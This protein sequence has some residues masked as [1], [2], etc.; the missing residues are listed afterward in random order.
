MSQTEEKHRFVELAKSDR[1]TIT[2]LCEE[3]GISR[4]T[5]H[6]WLY[7]FAS[8]GAA[9][10]EEHSRAPKRQ[11]ARTANDIEKIIVAERRLHETWGAKKIHARLSNKHGIERPP[12]VSTVGEILKRNGLIK[13]RRRRSGKFRPPHG[14]L[15]EP[16]RPNHVFAVDFKGWFETGDGVRFDPLTV[17]DLHSRYLLAAKGLPAQTTRLDT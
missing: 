3:F 8:N 17:T 9:G 14:Q 16:E 5:G 10:L 15:T 12:A 4:K 1:Y 2:E 13:K 7:R 11:A 6:K